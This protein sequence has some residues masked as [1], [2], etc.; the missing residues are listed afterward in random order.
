MTNLKFSL[1]TSRIYLTSKEFSWQNIP[2]NKPPYK[3][4]VIHW[5]L[6][7]LSNRHF[8]K[9]L[10]STIHCCAVPLRT[11]VCLFQ[12]AAVDKWCF[13]VKISSFHAYTDCLC[14]LERLI[15]PHW[16]TEQT[17][18]YHTQIHTSTAA[19]TLIQI[20]VWQYASWVTSAASLPWR[21]LQMS[22]KTF[23]SL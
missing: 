9:S 19:H 14:E 5:A 22:N 6:D 13:S 17:D 12:V 15:Y 10:N 20:T 21:P 18:S 7:Y 3:E 2:L 8:N 4:A 23:S 16:D 1:G 11:S